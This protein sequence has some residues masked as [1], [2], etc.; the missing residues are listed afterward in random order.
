MSNQRYTP[1]FKDEAVRQIIERGYSVS[2]VSE[3]HCRLQKPS[4]GVPFGVLIYPVM[5]T[6]FH[7]GPLTSCYSGKKLVAG[8]CFCQK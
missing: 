1:E 7:S 8:A 2:E 6:V 4:S 3:R 5:I